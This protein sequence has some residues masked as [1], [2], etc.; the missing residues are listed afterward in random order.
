MQ[1]SN[2]PLTLKF[3]KTYISYYTYFRIIRFL[4]ITLFCY[5]QQRFCMNQSCL[6][7]FES[8]IIWRNVISRMIFEIY[9]VF[10]TLKK[11]WQHPYKWRSKIRIKDNFHW[12]EMNWLHVRLEIFSQFNSNQI[13]LSGCM[14][15]ID[16]ASNPPK[17]KC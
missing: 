5:Y 4:K 13:F 8:G 9:W 10:F 7:V 2:L 15:L 6:S 11:G 3:R 1:I 16:I 14:I 12:L 17:K